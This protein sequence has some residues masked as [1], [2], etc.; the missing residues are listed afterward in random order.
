MRNICILRKY[1]A[2]LTFSV[3]SIVSVFSQ[4]A[5]IGLRLS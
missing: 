3:C 5:V 2:I 4:G 1:A